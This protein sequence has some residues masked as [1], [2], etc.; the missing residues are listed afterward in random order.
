MWEKVDVYPY[1]RKSELGS[2]GSKSFF[3]LI[4]TQLSKIGQA[5]KGVKLEIT[6]EKIV[7]LF[8]SL[9]LTRAVVLGEIFPFGVAILVAGLSARKSAWPLVL[10]VI[11][12]TVT[13]AQGA[14]LASSLVTMA[15]LTG[16]LV[17]Y[18]QV[19]QRNWLIVPGLVL[20]ATV[21]V[22]GITFGFFEPTLYNGVLVAVEGILAAGLTMVFSLALKTYSEKGFRRDEL[23]TEELG[24]YMV[25]AL[26]ITIGLNDLFVS[27]ISIQSVVSRFA[28]MAVALIYGMGPAAVTGVLLGVV[29]SFNNLLTPAI[30]GVYA[31]SA[32]L[33]GVFR[34]F[35]KVGIILGFFMGNMIF[36]FYMADQLV[37]QTIMIETAIAGAIFFIFPFQRLNFLDLEQDWLGK[38]AIK[39]SQGKTKIDPIKGRIKELSQ[40]FR[41][42]A[43]TFEETAPEVSG[44]EEDELIFINNIRAKVCHNCSRKTRCHEMEQDK[45]Y[46]S[47]RQIR[48]ALEKHNYIDDTMVNSHFYKKCN[49]IREM[50]LAA[51]CIWDAYQVN[52]YWKKKMI[53]TQNLVP[54]QLKG[55]S[56]IMDNLLD[57]IKNERENP[58]GLEE[59]IAAQLKENNIK[60]NKVKVNSGEGEGDIIIS[61]KACNGKHSCT[62]LVA[63]NVSEVVGSNLGVVKIKCN[64]ESE[65]AVCCYRLK[66]ALQFKLTMGSVA[67]AKNGH[68]V[69]GDNFSAIPLKDGRYAVML[70]DGMGAGPK[71]ALESNTTIALLEHLLDSGFDKELAIKTI[72]SILV[73]RSQEDSFATLDLAIIDQ[74]SGELELTKIGAA[75]SFLK[76]GR[77]V[78]VLKASSLP[79]G[80]L[81]RIETEECREQLMIGDLLIMISDGVLEAN[82]EILNK[83]DWIVEQLAKISTDDPQEIAEHLVFQAR[84]HTAEQSKDDMTVV[85]A[86]V[87]SRL[88]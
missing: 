56:L 63:P 52:R 61:Q 59:R 22:K 38:L 88:H 68:Q 11:V 24:C 70:S 54:N 28:I 1:H 5:T 36:S 34:Q 20:V 62:E 37:I 84:I 85:V 74:G 26:G 21:V 18:P 72:N 48:E 17:A 4:P 13:V 64:Y 9:L 33:A 65:K 57:D 16:L 66:K 73:L 60:V 71:A 50:L 51:N 79:I 81:N 67:V 87:D 6:S 14:A 23:T 12:G 27:S 31:F 40:I 75:S 76:R 46:V 43:R 29:P 53:D 10:G 41:E 55:V 30:A 8:L 35:E 83:E 45:T 86:R 39:K 78:A 82:R 32:V 49:N 15:V 44:L 80:I 3:N 47:F 42:M 58:K 19:T 69:S 2:A 25:M 7:F 77:N